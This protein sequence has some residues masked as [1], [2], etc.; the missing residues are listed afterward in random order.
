MKLLELSS[1]KSS[2]KT[3][4]F[5]PNGLTLIIGD[6]AKDSKLEGSSNGVGKTLALGLVHHCLGANVDA[7]I[8]AAVPDWLFRLKISLNQKEHIIERS[9]DGKTLSLDG[10]AIKIGGLRNWLNDCGAFRID[11]QIDG[12]SFRALIRRFARYEREDCIDPLKTKKETP[13]DAQLRSLYLLGLDCSLVQNKRR[14]KNELDTLKQTSK[15]WQH[16]QVLKDMFRAGAQPKVRAEW[17]ER[18]IPRIK[19]DLENFQIAEDYRAIE[20]QAAELTSQIRENE[21]GAAIIRFQLEGIDKVLIQQPDISRD[22]LLSLYEG[23]QSIFKPEILAHFDA[24]EKFHHSLA[25][26]RKARLEQD[27][28]TLHG[29]LDAIETESKEISVKR[30]QRLQALQGKRA[31]D[32]YA[33]LANQLAGLQEEQHRL[34]EFL[35]LAA[36]LKQREQQIKEKKV[37][38]DRTASEYLRG[39][40]ITVAD[41]FFSSLAEF[42][43]PRTPA[44]IVIENNTGD[45]QI[46]YDL[47]VQIEGDDSDG[48]NAAKILCFDWLLLMHGANHSMGFLWHDNRLFADIDP[49]PRAAWFSYLLDSLLN[50]GKQY[51]AT[52]NTENFEAMKGHLTDEKIEAL[53]KAIRLTL[54]GDKPENKL[55][56]IQFGTQ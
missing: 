38:E 47:T 49:R 44:G 14:H 46:R 7:K 28:L 43:Y 24:V 1:D 50:T 18:E 48:I 13:F 45:N 55:L 5:S 30:D 52:I 51:I 54:R 23:L 32:E 34:N 19:S 16:D 35:N 22:D 25:A 37:E 27:R 3:I 36:N 41:E 11:H 56:G 42:L 6:G 26:N 31:L 21:K 53:T 29:K 33:A 40:P 39:N 4:Q 17:L 20:L 10:K 15:T 9:G 8:K 12:L 2:F